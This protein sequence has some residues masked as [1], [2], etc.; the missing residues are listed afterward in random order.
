PPVGPDMTPP[1]VGPD[2]T[3]ALDMTTIVTPPPAPDMTLGP[4]MTPPPACGGACTGAQI[5]CGNTCVDPTS[6]AA[7]CGA[8]GNVCTSGVCGASVTA[9]M[10]TQPTNWTFNGNASYDGTALSGVLTQAVNGQTGTIIYNNPIATDSFDVTF[11]FRI[12]PHGADGMGFMIEKEGNTAIGEGGGGFAMTGLTG[13]G[14]ELDAYNNGACGD[15]DN[16]HTAVDSLTPCSDDTDC[17]TSLGVSASL[18]S[19]FGYDIG[20]GTWRTVSVHNAAG[21]VTVTINQGTSTNI[22]AVTSIALPNYVPGD[23]YYFGFGGGTGGYNERQE[24]RNV[25]ITFPTTRC[26]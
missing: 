17:P 4:D 21:V 23:K 11:D 13:Y 26:L 1:P 10:A 9:S 24:I 14:V 7:N 5:C 2:M 18:S 15:V 20:D 6:D 25:K 22:A 3:V 12:S 8:C 16:D 19:L